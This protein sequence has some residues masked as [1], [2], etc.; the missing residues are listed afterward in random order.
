MFICHLFM[1][2]SQRLLY[3][4][5]FRGGDSSEAMTDLT[6]GVCEK[7][8]FDKVEDKE[9]LFTK[10]ESYFQHHS[11]G[12]CSL[13]DNAAGTNQGLIRSHAYTINRVTELR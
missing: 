3:T 6:G 4:Y 8:Q 9:G 7:I 13:K 1:L 5:D 12:T 11:L 2:F 10:L